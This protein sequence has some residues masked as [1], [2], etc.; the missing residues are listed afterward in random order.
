MGSVIV[1]LTISQDGFIAGPD[2]GSELPLGR[3][4]EA[5]FEWMDAGPESNRVHRW[6]RPPDASKVSRTSATGS[7]PTRLDDPGNRDGDDPREE[8]SDHAEDQPV[9]V[10]RHAS[11]GG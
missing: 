10:V 3:G 4:G 7:C 6:L 2:N 9:P 11:R 1:D 5:L 8:G